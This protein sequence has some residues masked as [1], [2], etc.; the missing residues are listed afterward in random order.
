MVQRH[1]RPE[2]GGVELRLWPGLARLAEWFKVAARLLTVHPAGDAP[3]R[4][5][6]QRMSAVGMPVVVNPRWVSQVIMICGYSGTNRS[7]GAGSPLYPLFETMS[8]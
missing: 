4:H 7:G 3:E 5:R 1:V 2:A 6:S 8:W